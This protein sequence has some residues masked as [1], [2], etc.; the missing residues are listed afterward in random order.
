MSAA[1]L[2]HAPRRHAV[3]GGRDRADVIR[4]RAAAAADD[5]DETVARELAEEAAR[6]GRLLVVAAELVRQAGVRIARDPGGRDVRELLDERPH[7]AAAERAVD[8]DDQRPRMLD[9]GPERLGRLPGEIAPAAVDRGEG[10]PE[11]QLRRLVERGDDRGLAVQRV[12]DGLDQQE[13]DAA[14]AQRRG[15]GAR[16]SSRTASNVTGRNAGSSTR[17]ES[18]S[19]DVQRADRP[20]DEARPVRRARSSTRRRRGARGARPRRSSRGRRARARS[21]PGRSSS[22]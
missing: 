1:T 7:L 14:L 22:T 11:R 21:P 15:S 8:A 3:D 6:V 16:T 17:G 18:E 4:R 2:G 19:A 12:E 13:V 5:V 10:Q 20:G 9:R